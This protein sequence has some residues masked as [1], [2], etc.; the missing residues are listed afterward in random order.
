MGWIRHH[1]FIV[2]GM[3]EWPPSMATTK[4]TPDAHAEAERI[5]LLVSPIVEHVINGTSS[6]LVSPDGSKEGWNTSDEFDKK[7]HEFR[8]WLRSVRYD[9]GSSPFK[10]VEVEFGETRPNVIDSDQDR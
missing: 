8:E 7:R 5:G 6:F 10:W 2:T 1:A 9:D 4:S 3:H